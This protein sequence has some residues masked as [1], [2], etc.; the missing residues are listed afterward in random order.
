MN[1]V[2][3][4]L[5][6]INSTLTYLRRSVSLFS[7]RHRLAAIVVALAFLSCPA[8]TAQDDADLFSEVFGSQPPEEDV[9]LDVSV[10]GFPAGQ[11]SGITDF[12]TVQLNGTELVSL[13]KEW[14]RAEEFV[15]LQ[16]GVEPGEISPDALAPYGIEITPNLRQLA[17]DVQVPPEM[18]RVIP[19][20]RRRSFSTDPPVEPE[21]VS[22]YLNLSS[23]VFAAEERSVLSGTME[24]SV[25]IA[26][27]VARAEIGLVRP[28]DG[29]YREAQEPITL[30]AYQLLRDFRPQ[31]LRVTLGTVAPQP[32]GPFA[33]PR[34]VGVA[35]DRTITM[36]RDNRLI[37]QRGYKFTVPE[38]GTYRVSINDQ[39]VE[40]RRVPRGSYR[41]DDLRLQAGLNRLSVN[42]GESELIAWSPRLVAVGRHLWHLTG[43][44]YEEE[45]ERPVASA[46]WLWGLRDDVTVGSI[47]QGDDRGFALGVTGRTAT[48]AGITEATGGS[49]VHDETGFAVRTDHSVSLP[50]FPQAPSVSAGVEYRTEEYRLIDDAEELAA[51]R[52]RVI[53]DGSVSYGFA[54]GPQFTLSTRWRSLYNDTQRTSLSLAG[55]QRIGDSG[56]LS[57]RMGPEWQDGTMSWRGAIF[58][59]VFPGSGAS[60]YLGELRPYRGTGNGQRISA[61]RIGDT[62]LSLERSG[63][64]L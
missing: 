3:L 53:V 32:P 47:V 46:H 4:R 12:S 28:F 49:S 55:N 56:S 33:V 25:W 10:N 34:M 23:R 50:L 6:P 11:A 35:V 44:V 16:E 7:A 57:F 43:G 5:S 36:D 29:E 40:S 45:M 58:L 21:T 37:G 48:V 1:R 18:M 22:G 52:S 38:D 14:L 64:R 13:L 62:P 20:D 39:V 60:C 24:P 42:P 19:F 54:D 15:R 8:I 2:S 41:L 17:L 31:Q 30:D 26:G 9:T 63:A 59:R 27:N 61:G 51:S